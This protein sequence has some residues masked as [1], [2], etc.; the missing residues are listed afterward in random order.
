MVGRRPVDRP[1]VRRRRAEHRPE[2]R[3]EEGPRPVGAGSFRL[4]CYA[5]RAA[6]ASWNYALTSSAALAA[7]PRSVDRSA[8]TAPTYAETS[9]TAAAPRAAH[10]RIPR[11]IAA[12]ASLAKTAVTVA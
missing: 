7:R 2:L 10:A 12:N 3:R 1:G 8:R 4:R 9:S 5:A 11:P 6:V